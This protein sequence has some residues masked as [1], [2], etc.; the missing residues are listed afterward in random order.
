MWLE[1][2]TELRMPKIFNLKTDPFE[3]AD[4]TSNSYFDWMIS[5]AYLMIPAQA[6]VMQMAS[7]LI[8]FPLRQES[9]SFTVGAMLSKLNAGIG[10]S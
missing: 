3:R 5:H 2:F 9:A 6:Y 10:S 8:E 1:P 4:I 7:S